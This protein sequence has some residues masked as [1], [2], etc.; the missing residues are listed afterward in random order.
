MK[1]ERARES[2]LPFFVILIGILLAVFIGSTIGSGQ[3]KMAYMVVG[4]IGVTAFFLVVREKAWILIPATWMLSGKMVALPLPASAGQLCVLFAFGTYLLLKAFKVIRL[5]PQSGIVDILMLI[6][7]GYLVTVFIRNPVGVEALGSDRVGGKP[8]FDVFVAG[9]A[10]WVLARSVATP[11]DAYV[12]PLLGVTGY[13]LHAWINAIAYHFPFMVQPLAQLYSG[14]GAAE[15]PDSVTALESNSRQAHLQGIG[16]GLFSYAI[17]RWRPFTI[18]NPIFF[19]RFCVFLVALGLVLLSGFRSALVGVFLCFLLTT[20]LRSGLMDVIRAVVAVCLI[21]GLLVAAQGTLI[22]LP[23]PAQRALS[24]LP[25]KWDYMATKEAQGSTQWRLD[26]W[27]QMLTGNKYIENKLLGD[28]FGFTRYQLQVMA[29][30]TRGG[31]VDQQEN[32][33]ISGG[34]HSGPISTIRFVG[35]VGLALFLILLVL[36]AI[37]SYHLIRRAANTPYLLLALAVGVPLVLLPFTFVFIFGAF[38]GDLPNT[39]FAIGMLKLIENSLNAYEAGQNPEATT[40]V[41]PTP[42]FVRPPEF[43]SAARIG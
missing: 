37:R 20:F 15:N 26:M 5:K 42:T 36:A 33:M 34:V 39:I 31:N 21:L 22:N 23:M 6:N 1:L 17:Y 35:Y 11:K 14:I 24:F 32:L 16:V 9:C 38:E 13:G 18:I 43:V 41:R 3:T 8:Y 25:G 27:K 7:L 40:D 4:G 2:L 30:N 19:G 28:G 10:Y 12:V 29:A